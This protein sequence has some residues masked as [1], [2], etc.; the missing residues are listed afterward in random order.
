MISSR[1]I[2]RA[3]EEPGNDRREIAKSS[4]DSKQSSQQPQHNSGGIASS[5]ARG[6]CDVLLD[7]NR[8]EYFSSVKGSGLVGD[9]FYWRLKIIT[10]EE[11]VPECLRLQCDL[12]QQSL[13]PLLHK[14]RKN[15]SIGRVSLKKA[16]EI[17]KYFQH[18]VD[19]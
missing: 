5:D 19:T 12:S 2:G 10:S 6:A 17:E 18:L 4:T 16:D 13:M 14:L 3:S 8:P 11:S 15:R 1:L 7:V 9:A